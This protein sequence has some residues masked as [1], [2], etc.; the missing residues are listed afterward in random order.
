MKKAVIVVFMAVMAALPCG[1]QEVDPDGI[2]SIDGTVWE[3]L[4]IGLQVFPLPGIQF[5]YDLT[6][7][8]Y[9]DAVYPDLQPVEQSFYLEMLVVSI[10]GTGYSMTRDPGPVETR[11]YFGVLQPIGI[12][13]LIVSSYECCFL[14]LPRVSVAILLKTDDCWLG[15]SGV[16]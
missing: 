15:P 3:T 16:E 14:P 10:F 12:G 6:V 11:G 4:P 7:G 9:G 8:F 2:F 13:T 5:N 1:A